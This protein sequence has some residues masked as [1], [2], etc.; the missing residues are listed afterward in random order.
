MADRNSDG[1]ARK[2]G[3][4]TI[5]F[6]ERGFGRLGLDRQA[7][8]LS[9]YSCVFRSSS[10]ME[11]LSWRWAGRLWFLAIFPSPFF[12]LLIFPF[13][14]ASVH[15][16]SSTYRVNIS[17]VDICPISLYSKSFRVFIKVKECG[18]V[19]FRELNGSKGSFPWI[20]L[21]FLSSFVLYRF[22]P[23]FRWDFWVCRGLN[24]PRLYPKAILCIILLS[25][26]Q[27]P[28]RLGPLDSPR[29]NGSGP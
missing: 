18:S 9:W 22:C 8:G 21:D 23:S 11:S 6:V 7:V 10:P 16:P 14:F 29:V 19:R 26:G 20:F 12:R 24:C 27:S 1:F 4:P 15:C 25:L 28:P 3:A 17:Q 13:I 5:S 2:K